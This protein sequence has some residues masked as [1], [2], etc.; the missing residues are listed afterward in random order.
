MGRVFEGMNSVLRTLE[1]DRHSL[2][3]IQLIA[4]TIGKDTFHT[5]S[6]E[7]L[8]AMPTY[9]VTVCDWKQPIVQPYGRLR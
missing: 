9:V 6:L 2:C 3:T 1:G 5:D 7:D 8:P 4:I